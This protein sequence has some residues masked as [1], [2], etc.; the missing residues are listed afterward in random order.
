MPNIINIR[1]KKTQSNLS[2]STGFILVRRKQPQLN[3]YQIT[4]RFFEN[5]MQCCMFISNRMYLLFFDKKC[6]IRE[7]DLE[8]NF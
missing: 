6:K 5:F 2:G 4:Y 8:E 1:K 3:T 7:N